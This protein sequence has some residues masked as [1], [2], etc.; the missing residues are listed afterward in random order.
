VSR[1]TVQ[2]VKKDFEA[3]ADLAAFLQLSS[4]Y[5]TFPAEKA[6]RLVQ[7]PE[8]RFTPKHGSWL[9]IA[10]IALSALAA[11]CLGERRIGDIDTHNA[12]LSAW[13][14]Q[15]NRHQKGSVG[16]SLPPMSALNSS[17]FIRRL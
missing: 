11:Q 3:A 5:E 13:H 16:S 2:N 15:R 12:E 6:F 9:D 8:L 17:G 4:R 14:T 1:Q 7:K 10:E